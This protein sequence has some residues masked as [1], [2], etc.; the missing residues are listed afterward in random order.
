MSAIKIR[1]AEH[2]EIIRP[3]GEQLM[4]GGLL[5]DEQIKCVKGF[6]LQ[7]QINDVTL[8]E[9]NDFRQFKYELLDGGKY[10]Q[11]QVL[12]IIRTLR[13]VQKYWVEKEYGELLQEIDRCE[14]AE[15]QLY[16][17]IKRFLIRQG[18]HHIKEVDYLIRE[19]YEQELA[20]TKGNAHCLKYLKAFDR[21]KQ[22]DICVNMKTLSGM[23]QSKLIYNN[24]IVFLP[25]LPDQ[26]L[27]LQFDKVRD[28]SELVWDFSQL[29]SEGLKRQV[30]NLLMYI[31]DNMREDPKDRRV[32]YLLP[33]QWLYN[34]CVEEEIADIELLEL[35]QIEKLE[36]TIAQKVVNY[37]I[38]MQIVDN[39]R[40]ILFLNSHEIHWNANVWYIERFQLSPARVN[41][42]SPVMR[43]SFLEVS[44]KNSRALL[45]EYAKYQIGITDLSIG[46]IRGQ[47][48]DVKKFMEYFAAEDSILELSDLQLDTYLVELQEKEIQAE[49]YNRHITNIWKF[50]QYYV[51][52]DRIEGIPFELDYYLQK[53]YP[54]HHDR[55]VEETVYMEILNKLYLFPELSRLIFLHLWCTGLRIS[56]VCTLKRESYYWDGED[57]WIKVYQIKMKADKIIPIPTVLYWIMD[58]YIQK[59]KIKAKDY[60]F[61]SSNGG[62]YRVGSFIK[63]FKSNCEKNEIANSQYIF[64]S[65]DYRHTLATRFYEEGVSM[66]T[67]R[68]YL[69]HISENMTKQYIDYLPEKIEKA[70]EMYFNKPENNLA[71]AITIKKRGEKNDKENIHT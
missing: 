20:E 40:K 66:Q 57:A 52:N 22:Y 17:N 60:I 64:R 19:K 51:A 46:N 48:Y 56:E 28:K 11:K 63:T 10:I 59:N 3:L 34:F 38:S 71:T 4:V 37:K 69:G 15:I 58:F 67:I 53:T 8:I 68:D 23:R 5:K 30:F 29:A 65:H 33:L 21:I 25:Y 47:L 62:A 27:A 39:C 2:Y 14:N 18:I 41:P 26:E 44:N 36:N 6:L 70:N 42:S 7:K 49:T 35:A 31:L 55:S 1:K 16:G 45:Q 43:I 50:Y 32:R 61:T 54:V 24:Q 12:S 9:E 13:K